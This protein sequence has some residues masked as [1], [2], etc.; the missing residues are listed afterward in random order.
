[1][2]EQKS[3]QDADKPKRD[4]K[5]RLLPGST[6]N[7]KGGQKSRFRLLR[8]ALAMAAEEDP[9]KT[10]W[11]VILDVIVQGAKAGDKDFALEVLNRVEGKVA[12]KLETT[13]GP[14]F[15]LDLKVRRPAGGQQ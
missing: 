9:K 8:E 14:N 7:R 3:P 4:A 13:F 11:D 1:M 5:G 12:T 10:N 2:D 15:K 6:A